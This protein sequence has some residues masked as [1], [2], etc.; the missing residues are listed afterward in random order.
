MGFAWV[1]SEGSPPATSKAKPIAQDNVLRNELFEV[2]ISPTAGSIQSVRS[3]SQRGNQLSQQIAFRLPNQSPAAPG[4]WQAPDETDSY[5]TMRA[6]SV[7]ITANST[8]FGEIVS[9]GVLVHEDRRLAGFRQSVQVWSLSNVVRIDVELEDIE[10]PRADPWNS[11]YAARFAWPDE[12]AELWRGVSLARQQTTAGRFEAPE[13]IEID[14]GSGR[15]SLLTGGLP[16]HRR[17]GSRML[18]SLLVVRGETARRF[19]FGIGIDLPQSATAAIELLTPDTVRYET[20]APPTSTSG[21]FFHVGSKNVVAT[22]WQPIVAEPPSDAPAGESPRAITGFRAR[23]LE[24]AGR[25][26]HVQ[27]RAFRPVAVARQVDFLGQVLVQLPVES[28]M[29]TLDFAAHEWIEVEAMWS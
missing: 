10:E 12:T 25:P 4:V 11:Y 22:H 17:S 14:N 27:L 18:D 23:L 21:W 16:Y 19:V 3:F 8:V 28:D 29:I 5:T 13:Y 15:V 6:D 24:T 20:I 1:D 7:E 9:R 26:S 2:T